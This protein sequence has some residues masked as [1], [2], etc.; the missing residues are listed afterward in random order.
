[1]SA[2]YV[3]PTEALLQVAQ[4][5]PH[6]AAVKSGADEWSYAALW[7]RVRK[8]ANELPALDDT[9]NSIGLLMGLE[10][11]FVAA[12]HAIWLSG[13]TVVFLSL[14]WTPDVLQAVLER[15]NV[16]LVLFGAAEPQA[17][18]GVRVVATSGLVGSRNPP[19]DVVPPLP[20]EVVQVVPLICSITPTSGSTG[21]PKSIVYPMRRSLGVLSEE[22][23]T[24]FQ[25]MDGQWLRG[26]TT[27]LRPLFEIR[28]FMFNRTTLYLDPST[29][30]TDQCTTL[31]KELESE[32]NS[33]LLRVYF[34]PSVFRAFADFTQMRAGGSLLP[35]GFNRVYWMVIGG[36]SLSIR[37]LELAREIFPRATIACNY[38][39][40]EVGFAGISQMFIRPSDPMPSTISFGATQGCT[41][42]VLLDDSLSVIP[43][44]AEG[45]TGIIAFITCQSATHYLANEEAS[46]HAFRPWDGDNML[47]YTD[48]IGCM[49]ADGTIVV[50][51]R[52]SRNVKINGLFV[53]LDYVE[54]ALAPAL[55]DKS[56]LVT[57][58]KIV[59]SNATEKIVLFASTGTTDAMFLLKHARACLRASYDDTLAMVIGCVRCITEM[60]FNAS[61]KIDL[62]KL[63][64][65][66]D[67]VESLAPNLFAELPAVI[68]SSRID[69]LAEEIAASIAKLSKS[70][71][72]IPTDT[73]LLYTGLNSIT[74][75]RLYM[76]LQLEHEYEGSMADLFDE[77]VTARSLATEILGEDVTDEADEIDVLA[78]QIAAEVTKLSKSA[79]A[80][81]RDMPLLYSG[82]NSI[83]IVRLYM[84]LQSEH[85]YEEEMAHLFSEQVTAEVLAREIL[86][87]RC[88]REALESLHRRYSVVTKLLSHAADEPVHEFSVED[89]EVPTI[90][91]QDPE[92]NGAHDIAVNDALSRIL[93]VNESDPDREVEVFENE[94]G[95]DVIMS[96]RRPLRTPS[97]DLDLASTPSFRYASSPLD[98]SVSPVGVIPAVVFVLVMAH[99]CR[100]GGNR[101]SIDSFGLFLNVDVLAHSLDGH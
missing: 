68:H 63:Q 58:F 71:D 66:A 13:R 42:L 80:I 3:T 50:R 52:S 53:D 47:L 75:V 100:V 89:E 87:I 22:S 61:Y 60:P 93:I 17:M 14:K 37:D 90:S 27:F 31:C 76:W 99:A 51:G 33:Q 77:E 62:A 38:A 39:C 73:P 64:N 12:A 1:M 10:I 88:P 35:S 43:K 56:L 6:K 23:S 34:T 18:P 82:L 94:E 44:T 81:S 21:V 5:H 86:G 92:G 30:V 2:F 91:V 65:M 83:T 11:D 36:E 25:P 16:R 98:V 28:R 49:Q 9:G 15:A 72:A 57:S 84:W 69:A 29:S 97:I 26:G 55:A 74:A 4:Q 20:S 45:A 7:D 96:Y 48:D 46:R 67:S 54:R 79:E 32:H 95:A 101:G 24:L 59:K 19:T 70:P 85:E 78:G 40:S 41:D 8:I